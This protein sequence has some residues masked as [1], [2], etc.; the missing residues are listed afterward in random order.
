MSK[1]G[2]SADRLGKD[3]DAFYEA[4]M[5]AHDGLNATHSARLNA[6]LVLL[7]ANQV[8]DL[9]LLLSAIDRARLDLEPER[10]E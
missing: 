1:T 5:K 10:R 7:L 9:R 2:I 6:R 8:A 3:G 4:L